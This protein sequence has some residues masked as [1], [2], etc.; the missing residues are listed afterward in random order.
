MEVR[1]RGVDGEPWRTPP[2]RRSPCDG[3]HGR[4]A[5]VLHRAA[6]AI[7]SG[8]MAAEIVPVMVPRAKGDPIVV[9]TDEHPRATSLEALAKLR[10]VVRSD[11]TG[12]VRRGRSGGV[13]QAGTGWATLS[14]ADSSRHGSPRRGAS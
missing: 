9:D 10:P 11:Q 2:E 4:L 6:E 1:H 13:S 7:A 8:R 5:S 14:S 12:L 3:S